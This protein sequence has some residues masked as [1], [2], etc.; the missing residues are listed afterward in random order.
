MVNDAANW[1]S[2]LRPE[3]GDQR[4]G[5]IV[6]P[7]CHD[8][9]TSGIT[10][11]SI[12][13]DQNALYQFAKVITPAT[14]VNWSITQPDKFDLQLESGFRHLDMRI[15]DVDEFEP[16]MFR[17][18]HGMAADD[19]TEG[20]QHVARFS[21]YH[22]EEVLL[23]NMNTFAAAG[24]A[25]I[26]LKPI[27]EARKDVLS[28]L[29]LQ[30]LGQYMAPKSILSDNPTMNEVLATGRNVI[31][32]MEDEYIR[33]KDERYWPYVIW[34]SWTSAT[35]TE[36][37]FNSRSSRLID[38]RENHPDELTDLSGAVTPNEQ[39]IIA[40]LVNVY[41]DNETIRDF[42]NNT[43]PLLL[44]INTTDMSYEGLW[45]DLINM[46]RYGTNTAGMR[47]RP[48][49][50]YTN[51]ASVHYSGNNDM[52]RHWVARPG[53]YKPN[54]VTTDDFVT[55]TFVQTVI[56]ANL[57]E[58]P[59]EVTVAHQGNPMNGY[60]K[61]DHPYAT[62]GG[63]AGVNCTAV[64]VQYIIRDQGVLLDCG[65]IHQ[66]GLVDIA[67]GQYPP[68]AVCEIEVSSVDSGWMPL[69]TT[70][71]TYMFDNTLDV[72]IRGT[73]LGEGSGFAYVSTI[74][75][76]YGENCTVSPADGNSILAYLAW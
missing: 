37:L 13:V 16:G 38:I 47:A 74:Y 3:I 53:L 63:D 4:L 49:D 50:L 44:E 76:D 48:P 7:G 59:R 73:D 46:A 45:V 2:L 18:W 58:I 43:F 22:P 20:L 67:D 8:A 28:D 14:I 5:D 25:S 62:S 35:N 56:S 69:W 6:I 10:E 75:D 52:L 26:P 64:D 36:E 39:I 24:N 60:Y 12:L 33:A 27:P 34:S 30:H 17:W 55:S 68:S 54:V 21:A 9:G 15:A 23:L 32:L 41:G 57:G 1:M 42:I 40:G 71:I 29:L 65:V 11:D 31:M 61:W 51:G 66:I 19:V 70:N 72:Y